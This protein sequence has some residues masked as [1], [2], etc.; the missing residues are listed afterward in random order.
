MDSQLP[1]EQRSAIEMR[2]FPALPGEQYHNTSSATASEGF[3]IAKAVEKDKA[4]LDAALAFIKFYTGSEGATIRAQFGEV[5]SYNL[6]LSKTK[7]DIMQGKF[8]TFSATYPMGYVFDSIMDGEG[9]TLLNTDLQAMM[10]GS[11]E[12]VEIARKYE[13]WVAQNDSNRD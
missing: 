3:G 11:G 7:L 5:P 13:A 8:V 6:D 9:V 12:P 4:K 10:M 1:T 2:V